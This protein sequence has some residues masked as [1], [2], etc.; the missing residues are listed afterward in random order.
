M[1]TIT[2]RRRNILLAC[3]AVA[4]GG[5][6]SYRLYSSRK[7]LR[8][9][10]FFQSLS[11]ILEAVS[12]GSKSS[13]AVLNDLHAFLL[14]D[15]DEV[16]QTL[17]QLLKLAGSHEAQKSVTA[18]SASISRGVLTTILSGGSLAV[19]V[20]H[21]NDP[22]ASFSGSRVTSP[23]NLAQA[24]EI[25]KVIQRGGKSGAIADVQGLNEDRALSPQQEG[26]TE[27]LWR[28]GDGVWDNCSWLAQL[29][30]GNVLE[31]VKSQV[32]S[33]MAKGVKE[34]LKEEIGM[35]DRGRAQPGEGS[36]K[37]K[38][39]DK[40]VDKLF[41]ESGKGFAA[42][43]VASASRS[44]V[45]SVLEHLRTSNLS[46]QGDKRGESLKGLVKF[47][48]STKGRALVTD[49]IQTFVGTAVAVYLDKTKD[50]NTFDELVKG[51]VKPEHRGPITEL[52]TTVC[53]VSASSF[54]RASHEVLTTD[55]SSSTQHSETKLVTG[56]LNPEGFALGSFDD[57]DVFYG[58]LGN[59]DT[60]S[61][62]GYKGNNTGGQREVGERLDLI[63]GMSRVLAIPSNRQLIMDIAGTMTSE[64]VKSVI[65]VSLSKVSAAFGGKGKQHVLK[66][67]DYEP[68]K[69]SGVSDKLQ[70]VGDMTKTAVDKSMVLMTMCFAVCLHSVVGGVRML[71]PF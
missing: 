25:K 28:D 24:D 16:P 3:T 43:V 68:Q 14:S 59:L 8:V 29:S 22:Q 6:V 55:P 11:S 61:T 13:A 47:A 37:E 34:A 41:S 32:D 45:G 10:I 20:K 64:G 52:L 62:R 23:R 38:F 50:I 1:L 56:P 69:R 36:V 54:V 7:R 57:T 31:G 60:F 5:Y 33:S 4:A 40:L 21:G 70:M 58:H 18:L 67:H 42:A 53:Q 30:P 27:E 48:G 46:S 12:Q 66:E 49:C 51:L 39:A 26:N 71:Q 19:N 9:Y 65:D 2:R 17:K 15:D 44:L 35:G 63:E